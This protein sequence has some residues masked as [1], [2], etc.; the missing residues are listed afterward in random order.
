MEKVKLLSCAARSIRFVTRSVSFGH[1]MDI[2]LLRRIT[3]VNRTYDDDDWR[4]KCILLLV[5]APAPSP[6]TLQI[7]FIPTHPI[8]M[9]LNNDRV[10]YITCDSQCIDTYWFI[11]KIT[12]ITIINQRSRNLTIVI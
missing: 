2:E 1:K 3:H 4:A 8:T 10:K 12:L 5:G 9:S 7:P 11:I 6:I